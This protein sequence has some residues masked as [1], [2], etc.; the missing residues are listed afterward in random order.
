MIGGKSRQVVYTLTPCSDCFT[1]KGN[2]A[3]SGDCSISS[4]ERS[5]NKCSIEICSWIGPRA[6]EEEVIK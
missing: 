4:A 3:E 5:Q 6:S 2:F 1:A